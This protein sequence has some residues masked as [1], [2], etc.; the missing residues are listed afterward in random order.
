MSSRR[1]ENS[2]H[3]SKSLRSQSHWTSL[4]HTSHWAISVARGCNVPILGD[5]M[6]WLAYP[7]GRGGVSFLRTR[8]IPADQEE[9]GKGKMHAGNDAIRYWRSP[10]TLMMTAMKG[11]ALRVISSCPK[12]A[13]TKGETEAQRDEV[14]GGCHLENVHWDLPLSGF[15]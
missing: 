7:W 1:K 10:E 15:L 5:A 4:S 11:L 12:L 13:F 2:Q 6:C 3:S 9:V 14:P 8:W